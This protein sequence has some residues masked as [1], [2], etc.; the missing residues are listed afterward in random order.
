MHEFLEW[1][2]RV[3]QGLI[4]SFVSGFTKVAVYLLIIIIAVIF[5]IVTILIVR[6]IVDRKRFNKQE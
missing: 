1:F 6:A 5:I 3:F 4:D 2:E